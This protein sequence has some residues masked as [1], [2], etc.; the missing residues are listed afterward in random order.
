MITMEETKK[1]IKRLN[2]NATDEQIEYGLNE[3]LE[4]IKA[5]PEGSKIKLSLWQTI[6]G[7]IILKFKRI[8]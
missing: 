1:A 2:P 5:K 7:F 3:A 6:K 4:M 8:K